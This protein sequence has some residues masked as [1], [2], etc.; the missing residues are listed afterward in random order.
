MQGLIGIIIADD[1]RLAFAAVLPKEKALAIA[2]RSGVDLEKFYK[3]AKGD[4]PDSLGILIFTPQG[5]GFVSF[6]LQF[7]PLQKPQGLG[8]N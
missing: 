6:P 3:F 1:D 8:N 2:G 5:E 4:E 7:V